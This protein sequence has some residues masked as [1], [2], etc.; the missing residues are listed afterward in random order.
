MSNIKTNNINNFIPP[1]R[2][3]RT[4]FS[5]EQLNILENAFRLNTYPDVKHREEIAKQTHLTESK[6]QVYKKFFI[7]LV[8]FLNI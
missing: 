4:W 2:K 6:I 8:L 3:T 5:H 7:V 1:I